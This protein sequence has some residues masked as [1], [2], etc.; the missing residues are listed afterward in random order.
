MI[1]LVIGDFEKCSAGKYIATFQDDIIHVLHHGVHTCERK[2]KTMRP[3]KLV[4][5]SIE[6]NP[7]AKPSEIQSEVI[8]ADLRQ[9]KS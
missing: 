6:T 2:R 8:L 7:F 3:I 5:S 1:C 4:E 9:R